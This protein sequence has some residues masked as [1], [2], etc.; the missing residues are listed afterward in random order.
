MA[1]PSGRGPEQWRIFTRW[2]W[3]GIAVFRRSAVF[4]N[5]LQVLLEILG[6]GVHLLFPTRIAK[7]LEKEKDRDHLQVEPLSKKIIF[8][9]TDVSILLPLSIQ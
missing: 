8:G 5:K 3:G 7:Q 4:R 1:L 6:D 2:G 9:L